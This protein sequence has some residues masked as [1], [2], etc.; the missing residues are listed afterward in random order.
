[1]PPSETSA[2][3]GHA[4][5]LVTLALTLSCAATP[6][7]PTA[8]TATVATTVTVTEAAH[9]PRGLRP[10]RLAACAPQRGARLPVH[11]APSGN[12]A[13][14]RG[15]QRGLEFVAREAIAWQGQH[16]C[17][18]CH[19]QAVTFE[20]LT[21]G[22]QHRYDV[23]RE[24]FD[25]VLYGLTDINGGHRHAG[26]LS[27]GGAPGHLIET[28]RAFG[29]AA[30]ARYDAALG[31]ELRDDLLAVA[32]QL[33][34]F[35]NE[36]GSVRTTDTRF[37]VVAGLM[38]ATTQALQTWHQAHAR[39][40]DEQW[41]EPVRRAET[42]MQQQARRLSDDPEATLVDLNYAVM[43]LREAGAQPGEPALRALAERIRTRQKPDGG[44]AYRPTETASNAFATGQALYALRTL[45]ASDSDDTVSRGM[46]WLL[47]HQATDGGWSHDGSGKAEAMWAVFG[48]VSLDVLSVDA[49]GVRDG[50][51]ASGS[52]RVR[53]RAT[54][55]S[56]AGV[57]RLDVLVDDV[58][59]ARG[60]GATVEHTVDVS[61]LDAGPHVLDLVA[62]NARGQSSRRRVEFYTG[63]H[64]L[65]RVGSHFEGNTTAL[66][67][68]NVAPEGVRGTVR[69]QVF[70]TREGG[71]RDRA[72]YQHEE[73]ARQG[74]M[75][76]AWAGTGSDGAALPRGRYVA[77]V[78][79]VDPA[80][81]AVQSV[82]VPFVHDTPEAQREAF[83][84]VAGNL[85]GADGTSA[86]NAV[87]E[88]V[89]ERGAVVQR[90]SS[91]EQGNYRFR[92]VDQGN[93][94]V[95][96]RRAGYHAAET[97]VQAARGRAA[98]AA[99]MQMDLAY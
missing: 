15:A 10:V 37:P 63:E 79:F 66:S 6:R 47:E 61:A 34:P 80:G 67:W 85:Q 46:T 44:W 81:R 76:A 62:T 73:A 29:G 74:P 1:M 87:V 50:E 95:R 65:T 98:P 24:Q 40:A 2:R 5:G 41:L 51:H 19:V 27:V 35:Q 89:D 3:H 92:N 42:W 93:Y 18:G 58:P 59:L 49:E 23:S 31:G 96:V 28:A 4:A 99:S 97:R 13:A 72:V 78:T 32:A 70:T 57:E 30:F 38:Q 20:A 91:T 82:E 55:N 48:L 84:E 77:A 60:C 39:T 56:G 8:A 36:D 16:R 11:T 22:R 45:G 68:R 83:A 21:V 69:L 90:T 7:R 53:G 26:G 25:Q 71:A 64:Y 94:R 86:A 14:R 54:D 43:G 52:L 9:G 17:Y 88:L 75:R 12:E 33:R